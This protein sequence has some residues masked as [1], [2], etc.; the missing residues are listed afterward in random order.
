MV[1]DR[2]ASFSRENQVDQSCRS[3]QRDTLVCE[4]LQSEMQFPSGVL[5]QQSSVAE[6]E[7]AKSKCLA[8]DLVETGVC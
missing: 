7:R 5:V 4:L 2:E 3:E 8:G 6:G 1:F